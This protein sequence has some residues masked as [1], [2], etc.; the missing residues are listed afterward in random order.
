MSRINVIEKTTANPEQLELLNAIESQLG[1]VP[2]FLKVFANSPVALRAFLGLHTVSNAGQLDPLNR[3]RIALALAQQKLATIEA[4]PG[5]LR[6]K[7]QGLIEHLTRGLGA[8][9]LGQYMA[10][11]SQ[12]VD[13]ARPLRMAGTASK[14]NGAQGQG[15]GYFHAKHS[16]D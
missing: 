16:I 15:D 5:V 2:N 10:L 1:M 8:P 12:P 9:L 11:S 6:I 3:G 14:K 7:R 4:G 13:S